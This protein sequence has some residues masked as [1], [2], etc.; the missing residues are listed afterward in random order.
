[1]KQI[2][3]LFKENG[4]QLW[5]VGGSV[6]DELLG[7]VPSDIDFATDATPDEMININNKWFLMQA[8]KNAKENPDIIVMNTDLKMWYSEN[9][10]NHGTIIFQENGIDYE[11]TTFRKDVS[12]DGRNATVEFAKTIGEDLSRRDFTINSLAVD[13]IKLSKYYEKKDAEKR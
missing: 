5:Q 3:K 4:Y 8:K 6:R 7:R 2:I 12:T 10:K 9:G 13:I 1:M 11:I